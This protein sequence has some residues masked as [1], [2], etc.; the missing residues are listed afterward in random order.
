MTKSIRKFDLA[1]ACCRGIGARLAPVSCY[2]SRWLQ[3]NSISFVLAML[4]AVLGFP[5]NSVLAQN[6]P[7]KPIRLI[8]PFPPGGGADILA[9]LLSPRVGAS[10]GQQLVIDNRGGAGGNIGME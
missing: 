8:L 10:L 7:N 5:V 1:D 9:R 3:E 6:Y 4:T 2:R